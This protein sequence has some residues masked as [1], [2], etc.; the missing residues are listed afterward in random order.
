[1]EAPRAPVLDEPF[2]AD[3][4]G[5]LP[6][7]EFASLLG[8]FGERI[9][10]LREIAQVG[11]REMLA[12]EAH[13]IISTAGNLGMARTSELARALEE[14]CKAAAPPEQIGALL[15]E[16]VAAAETAL[17]MVRRSAERVASDAA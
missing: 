6:A 10:R 7:E 3:L 2:I 17:A 5:M 12:R 13:V 11:G 15:G 9:T 16:L 14:A 4:I 8:M 1:V